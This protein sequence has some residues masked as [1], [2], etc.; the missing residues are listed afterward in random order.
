LVLFKDGLEITPYH[1][2]RMENKWYFPCS[3]QSPVN[4]KCDAVY[5]FVLDC[6]HS[7]IINGIEC[8]TLGH[9]F[10]EDVVSHPYFGSRLVIED[11]MKLPGWNN[12]L[13][14]FNSGCVI[15]SSITDLICGFNIQKIISTESISQQVY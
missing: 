11:I 2:I 1:P 13:I 10:K 3:L 5:S 9:D 14:E 4:T 6:H 7:M 15:K 12:G 8:V